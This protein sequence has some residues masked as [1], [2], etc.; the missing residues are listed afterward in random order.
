MR[1]I[2]ISCPK[3][4][5][6]EVEAGGE[7]V[8]SVHGNACRR[9]VAYAREEVTDPRRTITTTVR[10]RHGTPAVVPVRSRAPIPKAKVRQALRE[11]REVEL[12]APV[13]VGQVVLESVAGTGVAVVAT[14]P[15]QR[16]G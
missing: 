9:G 2:C 4:C 12:Q 10:V 6:L 1:L 5:E 14:R 3:G 15:V 8:R 11:V 16:R 13:A 7:G